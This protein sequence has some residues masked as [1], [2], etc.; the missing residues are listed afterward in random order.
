[1]TTADQDIENRRPVWRALSDLFLDTELQNSHLSY[2]A[3]TLAESPYTL[4]EIE[5]I[6]FREVYPVCIPNMH[7]VAGE[8]SGFNYEWLEE[9]I[10]KHTK[11]SWS[12]SRVF[13]PSRWMIRDDWNR[14][15]DLYVEHLE[16]TG[17]RPM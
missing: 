12:L 6:L 2:I 13:Q 3:R 5:T 11:C 8:W 10:L 14:V 1:M 4:A 16:V 15:K 17:A 9:T 7:C